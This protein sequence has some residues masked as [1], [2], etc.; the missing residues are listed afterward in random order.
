MRR[1]IRKYWFAV[2]LLLT[3]LVLQTNVVKGSGLACANTYD[4]Y[5]L[6]FDN[7]RIIKQDH[8]VAQKY[9]VGHNYI[10][11][12]DY[13]S[14]LRVYYNS[15]ALELTSGISEIT[16]DDSMFV[17]LSAGT[18]RAWKDGEVFLINRFVEFY[19]VNEGTVVFFDQNE[20]TL[21]VWY[22]GQTYILDENHVEFPLTSMQISYQTVAWQTP[23]YQFKLFFNGNIISKPIYEENLLYQTGK[24]FCVINNPVSHEFE[25]L[26]PNG[27]YTLESTHAKWW[28]T[29]YDKLLYLSNSDDLKVVVGDYNSI[30]G[31][32]KPEMNSLTNRG[33]YYDRSQH[34]YYY[35]NHIERFIINYIPHYYYV[36]NDYFMFRNELGQIQIWDKGEEEF[37]PLS[38][39][40]E[41]TPMTDVLVISEATKTSFWYKNKRWD[42]Q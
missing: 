6:I 18:L 26:T 15:H 17:W 20:R 4:R 19:K 13:M 29:K 35:E 23:D 2:N 25:M 3:V 39:A 41:I 34:V 37:P 10:A 8:N 27:I 33:L 30:I 14:S 32:S 9:W 28:Q 24:H 42:Y 40:A 21:N 5:F 31:N 7:G 38:P 1:N 16:P 11:F 12:V 22:D 36:F